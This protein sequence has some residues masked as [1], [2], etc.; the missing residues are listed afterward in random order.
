MHRRPEECRSGRLAPHAPAKQHARPEAQCR[1]ASYREPFAPWALFAMSALPTQQR[2]M[3]L[4]APCCLI[5]AQLK[6]QMS[7]RSSAED[8][9]STKPVEIVGRLSGETAHVFHN[10][11]TRLVAHADG[12]HD[13]LDIHEGQGVCRILKIRIHIVRCSAG[14][15]LDVRKIHDG[16]VELQDHR[17]E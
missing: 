5:C 9:L 7:I 4:F 11:T 13:L 2:R 10:R 6:I 12:P 3:S 16:F 17:R 14:E 15:A 1:A 8:V